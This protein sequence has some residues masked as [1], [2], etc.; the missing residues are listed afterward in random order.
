MSRYIAKWT[1]QK[2]KATYNVERMEQHGRE[3]LYVICNGGLLQL[4]CYVIFVRDISGQFHCRQKKNPLT[5]LF[6]DDSTKFKR[7]KVN[8]NWDKREKNLFTHLACILIFYGI[9]ELS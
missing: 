1:Y 8:Q 5:S 7:K 2:V 4:I 3:Y 6:S 9:V